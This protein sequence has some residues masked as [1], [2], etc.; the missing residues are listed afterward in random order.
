MSWL[1]DENISH[2]YLCQ[3]FREQMKAKEIMRL[4]GAHHGLAGMMAKKSGFT[5][6][7]LSGGALS[8]SKGLPDIG[9]LTHE[10]IV[11]KAKELVNAAN[12]P[13]LVDIDTGYGEAYNTVRLVQDLVKARVAAVQ[14][15]DQVFPKKCGHLEGKSLVPIEEVVEKIELIKKAAPD[16]VIVARTDAL[17]VTSREDAVKRAKAY[18]EAGAECVFPEAV[19]TEEDMEYLAHR[20]QMPLLYNMTEFGK[21]PYKTS[22]EI[23]KLGFSLVIYPVTSLRVA[24][25][26]I[27][28]IY[29]TIYQDGTQENTLDRMQTR[30][31]LYE[32]IDYHKYEDFK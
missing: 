32:L 11:T 29:E 24:L 30:E 15:E 7:Y 21:T 1:L 20:L 2:K 6:L 31:E 4:V 10:E 9:L 14:L 28:H 3:S 17:A 26:A 12:L 8:A 16:V 25:K 23:E 5:S 18:I 13:L 19:E 22:D 27:E